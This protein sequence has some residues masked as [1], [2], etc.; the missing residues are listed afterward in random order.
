MRIPVLLIMLGAASAF[1]VPSPQMLRPGSRMAQL[2]IAKAGGA[3]AALQDLVGIAVPGSTARD[4]MA[5]L[6]MS[7]GSSSAAEA[8]QHMPSSLIKRSPFQTAVLQGG[9]RTPTRLLQNAP[10]SI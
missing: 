3:L 2:S 5:A 6:R 4:S 10:F 7:E 1:I 9:V 8:L